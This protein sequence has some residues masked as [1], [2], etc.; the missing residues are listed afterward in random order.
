DSRVKAVVLRINSPGGTVAGSDA[1]FHLVE[2][3]RAETGKPVV[4]AIQE[5]GASGGYYVAL[6]ADEIH[7]QPTSIVGSVGV[8]IQTFDATGTMSMIGLEQRAYTSGDLK[9]LGSPLEA[10]TD[11]QSEVFET[12]VAEM[13]D[14]FAAKVQRRSLSTEAWET[15]SDGRVFTG[16]SA[17]EL[18]MID[19]VGQLQDAIARAGELGGVAEPTVVI[20]KRPFGYEGSVYAA[21]EPIRPMTQATP[22]A[23]PET[24]QPLPGGAYYLWRP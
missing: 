11:E 7:A 19:G 21:A 18:G 20:F 22:I 14:A 3:F 6:A 12:L 24:L 9:T 23:L 17:L 10:R 15:V 5:L 16:E 8:I 1:L 2:T 4:A 13:F